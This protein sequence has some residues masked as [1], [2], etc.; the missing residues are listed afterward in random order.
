MTVEDRPDIDQVVTVSRLERKSTAGTIGTAPSG[1]VWPPEAP[2]PV[3]PKLVIGPWLG[4]PPPGGS[5]TW[6]LSWAARDAPGEPARP[7]AGVWGE[8]SRIAIVA[9]LPRATVTTAITMNEG[10]PQPRRRP[11]PARRVGDAGLICRAWSL[12]RGRIVIA[13]H[14]DT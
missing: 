14:S 5:E 8:P 4:L 7:V 9:R 11:L 1:P 13:A 10:P 2:G 3:E 6:P 12:R